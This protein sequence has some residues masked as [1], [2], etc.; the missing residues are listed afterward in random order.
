MRRELQRS[1]RCDFGHDPDC[2]DAALLMYVN[3]GHERIADTSSQ[4]DSQ[5]G[6]LQNLLL[7]LDFER[8]H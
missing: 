8:A 1:A 3:A 7:W 5:S 2:I 6:V 4:P